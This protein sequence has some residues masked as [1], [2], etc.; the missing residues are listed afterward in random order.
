MTLYDYIN[1]EC[2]KRGITLK[3]LA[4]EI[5]IAYPTINNIKNKK[6]NLNTYNKLMTY[7]KVDAEFLYQLPIKKD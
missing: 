5:G 4:K 6:P 2:I 3:Q 1:I 7:F